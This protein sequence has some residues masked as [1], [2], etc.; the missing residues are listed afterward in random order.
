[1]L[2][3]AYFLIDSVAPVDKSSMSTTA[4]YV[5]D[6]L[7]LACAFI[8]KASEWFFSFLNTAICWSC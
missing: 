5:K 2:Y 3:V 6:Q 1:M 7:W 4:V 8:Q